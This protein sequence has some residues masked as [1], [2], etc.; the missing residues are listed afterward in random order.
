MPQAHSKD[1]LMK[2]FFPTCFIAVF[3]TIASVETAIEVFLCKSVNH[4][5]LADVIPC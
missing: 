4:Y 3:V 2:M 1:V 5:Q